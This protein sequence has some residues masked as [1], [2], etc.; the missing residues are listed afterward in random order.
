MNKLLA[1][2]TKD[3]LDILK[4]VFASAP[5]PINWEALCLQ[6]GTSTEPIQPKAQSYYR[7]LTGAMNV[8]YESTT[9]KSHLLLPLIPSPELVARNE[10]VGDAWGRKFI[11]YVNVVEDPIMRR[12][13]KAFINS[14]ASRFVDFPLML[15]FHNEVVLYDEADVPDQMDFY[16]DYSSR[17]QLP[18]QLFTDKSF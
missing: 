15:A 7:A 5:F 1:L 13:R 6:I 3:T 10:E 8:W 17:G 16:M 2:P 4:T 12:E 18:T 11:P 9:G 14:V